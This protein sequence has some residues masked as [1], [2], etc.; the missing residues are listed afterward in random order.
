M[1]L[2]CDWDADEPVALAL[3]RVHLTLDFIAALGARAKQLSV[4]QGTLFQAPTPHTPLAPIPSSSPRP[5]RCSAR[6]QRVRRPAERLPPTRQA[7]MAH[8]ASLKQSGR[9]A[10]GEGDAPVNLASIRLMQRSRDGLRAPA[11]DDGVLGLSESESAQY[12]VAAAELRSLL[13]VKVEDGQDLV[14]AQRALAECGYFFVA[15]K[16]A[17]T[18]RKVSETGLLRTC[19]SGKA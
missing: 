10:E 8:H 18:E 14:T 16:E 11:T 15:L 5:P 2:R 7:L 1:L 6:P 12:A 3:R 9:G 17:A 13:R 19:Q 4:L